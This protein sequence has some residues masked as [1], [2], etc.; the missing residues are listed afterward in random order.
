MILAFI[1]LLFDLIYKSVPDQISNYFVEQKHKKAPA[2]TRTAGALIYQLKNYLLLWLIVTLVTVH[3]NIVAC[4]G[5]ML[6][7]V[8]TETAKTAFIKVFM[9]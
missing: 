6:L 4:L 3:C 8:A 1:G 9:T 2:V 5:G 7:I